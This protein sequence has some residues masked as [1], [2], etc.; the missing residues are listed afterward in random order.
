MANEKV[1]E[2]SQPPFNRQMYNVNNSYMDLAWQQ[3]F[4]RL[5]KRV[6]GIKA[7]SNSDLQ[8]NSAENSNDISSLKQNVQTNID[9]ISKLDTRLSEAESTLS[10][11]ENQQDIDHESIVTAG[12]LISQLTLKVDTNTQNIATNTQNISTN[13]QDITNLKQR[14]AFSQVSSLPTGSNY[15]NTLVFYSGN[16]CYTL[17]GTDY[18]KISDNSPVT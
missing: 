4:N 13:T 12:Q 18:F 14:K 5:Y 1:I 7:S 3:W 8:D 17:N 15:A 10:S 6:G 16:M 2:L 11:V 9:N